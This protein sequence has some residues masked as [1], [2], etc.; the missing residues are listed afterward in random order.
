MLPLLRSVS[1]ESPL[2]SGHKEE[3]LPRPGWGGDAGLCAPE[4]QE[5]P[6]T[7]TPT[8]A[9]GT[10][11]KGVACEGLEDQ[12]WVPSA[13]RSETSQAAPKWYVPSSPLTGEGQGLKPLD[14]IDVPIP[15]AS[16]V[17]GDLAAFL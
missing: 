5:M 6:S 14:G 11:V 9:R 7:L 1:S 17:P 10:H 3:E 8:S 16:H 15:P 12:E 13:T 4:S 2:G